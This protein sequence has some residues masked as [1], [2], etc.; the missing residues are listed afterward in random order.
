MKD[1][2]IVQGGRYV[3]TGSADHSRAAI[4]GQELF[5]A[6]RWSVFDELTITQPQQ[7]AR[8]VVQ[9]DKVVFD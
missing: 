3:H 9:S 4:Q 5:G 6:I 7:I 8:V 2:E 1:G